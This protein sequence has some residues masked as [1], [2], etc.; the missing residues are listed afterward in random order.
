MKVVFFA[1]ISGRNDGVFKKIIAQYSCMKEYIEDIHLIIISDLD[2]DEVVKEKTKGFGKD[3]SFVKTTNTRNTLSNRFEKMSYLKNLLIKSQKGTLIYLRYPIADPLFY[4]TIQ[5]K[6]R[7]FLV[8][9][10]QTLELNELLAQRKYFKYFLEKILGTCILNK[11]D[12]IAGVTEEICRFELARNG[13]A[14]CF[15]ASN[16]IDVSAVPTRKNLTR[17][18]GE[19]LHLLCVAQVAKWHGLDR[20]IGGLAD[21]GKS[22]VYIHIVGDGPAIQQLKELVSQKHLEDQVIF[23]G[24]KTGE[25][26]DEMFNYCHIAVGSLGIHRLGLQEG[27]VLKV[28]EYCARGIPFIYSP[29]DQD[30]PE[31][32]PFRLKVPSDDSPINIKEVMCFAK[33]V[34]ADRE[35]PQIMREYALSNLD[36][37]IKMRKL[38]SFFEEVL[39]KQVGK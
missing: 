27:S 15:V 22:T 25:E 20:L 11:V 5:S 10:H 29:V 2:P 35:H 31:S 1:I 33:K 30:F 8:T 12:A 28:R 26:L 3:V 32:F 21:S 18:N 19:A 16:G 7:S 39:K 9:E 13:D 14:P 6:R 38:K 17:T 37:K 23:H 36:W 4:L 34:L 24:F